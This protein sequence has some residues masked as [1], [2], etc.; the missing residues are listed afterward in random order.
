M[1]L[2]LQ[3]ENDLL[4]Q[5]LNDKSIQLNDLIRDK[6][7]LI[8]QLHEY[9]NDFQMFKSEIIALR[10]KLENQ[11]RELADNL[12][13]THNE[14]KERLYKEIADKENYQQQIQTLNN[15]L[16]DVRVS[17][18]NYHEEK[19]KEMKNL[20]RDYVIL[21]EEKRIMLQQHEKLVNDVKTLQSNYEVKAD[22]AYQYEREYLNIQTQ[23]RNMTEQMKELNKKISELEGK[24]S[25]KDKQVNMLRNKIDG[26]KYTTDDRAYADLM[27]KYKEVLEKKKYYKKQC[28]IT[29][30]NILA[31]MKK[32]T[33]EQKREIEEMAGGLNALMNPAASQSQ[34]EA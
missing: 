24:N 18:K 4:K 33:P 22:Q 27:K 14:H 2:Q 21:Q 5:K 34:S 29:N 12:E 25:D 31:I 30:N 17:F 20:E 13:Q 32:V 11:D 26:M 10:S 28:K 15:E 9:E 23:Y 7:D 19:D 1:V 6:T 3:N 16:K 8:K